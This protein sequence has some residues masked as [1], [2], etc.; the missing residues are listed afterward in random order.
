M[1]ALRPL[2]RWFRARFPRRRRRLDFYADGL[3]VRGKTLAHLSDQRFVAAWEFARAGNRE[4]WPQRE[5][6]PD[7]RW[8]AVT[9]CWAARHALTLD[10]DFVECGVHTGL[11]SMTVCRYLGFE[12][13][14][15][16]FYLFDTFE[17]IPVE[18][19]PESER[20]FAA[21]YNEKLYFNVHEIARRNFAGYPNVHLV[22]GALPGSLPEDRPARVAYLSIDLNSATFERATI[23]RLWDRLVPGAVVVIDDYGFGGH[24][25]QYAMWNEFAASKGTAVLYVPTG[26]GL[27]IRPPDGAR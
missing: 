16:A 17:G 27:L 19:L 14:D 24:E 6:V 7:I 10:G 12:K 9:C 26:Q 13:L 11:L 15:R 25:A 8:R 4:G 20:G 21:E 23:E 22:R 2:R 18:G 5:D 1:S 3:G